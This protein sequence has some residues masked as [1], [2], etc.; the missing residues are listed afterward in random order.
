VDEITSK[1]EIMEK[2]N[3]R[4]TKQR[5]SIDMNRHSDRSRKYRLRSG[6]FGVHAKKFLALL[7]LMLV[8]HHSSLL[9]CAAVALNSLEHLHMRSIR[10]NTLDS[11]GAGNS[12]HERP[13]RNHGGSHARKGTQPNPQ[14]GS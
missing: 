10:E 13:R 4:R 1:R 11:G 8:H 5:S 3:T 7:A 12:V 9:Q 6:D 14:E 2:V